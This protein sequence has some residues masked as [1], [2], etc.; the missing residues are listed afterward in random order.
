LVYGNFPKN[1]SDF[2]KPFIV[3]VFGTYCA[4]K[5]GAKY[6]DENEKIGYLTHKGLHA[7]VGGVGGFIMS[8][9]WQGACAGAAGAACAEIAFEAMIDKEGMKRKSED[10]VERYR[11]G[12]NVAFFE[13]SS[14][15]YEVQEALAKIIGTAV[16]GVATGNWQVA[17]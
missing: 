10:Y 2:V 4:G 7:I 1:L 14:N 9:N 12:E 17:S 16:G 15:N 8:G 11:K 5:I 13:D 6:A 3:E